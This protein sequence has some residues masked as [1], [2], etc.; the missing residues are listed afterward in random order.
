MPLQRVAMSGKAARLGGVPLQADAQS[1]KKRRSAKL[2][3][4]PKR[5]PLFAASGSQPLIAE[6]LSAHKIAE[7]LC[8]LIQIA[9]RLS[10]YS[11]SSCSARPL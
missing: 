3:S 8:P 9:E 4:Y 7:R 2:T 11:I 10:A 1:A 5:R 6:R